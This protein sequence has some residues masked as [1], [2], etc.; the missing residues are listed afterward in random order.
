M[1]AASPAERPSSCVDLLKSCGPSPSRNKISGAGLNPAPGT[2][3]GGEATVD[4]PYDADGDGFFDASN[5]DCAATY[6]ADRLDC[7]DQDPAILQ[8]EADRIG[9]PVMVKASAGGGGIGM[10]VAQ[11]DDQLRKAFETARSRAER[12]FSDPAVFLDGQHRMRY[13]PITDPAERAT[14]VAALK[15]ATR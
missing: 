12:F 5:P 3:D 14:I 1:R 9:Y 15:A 7:N 6:A 8:H 2:A 13:K 10:S 11:D 4:A